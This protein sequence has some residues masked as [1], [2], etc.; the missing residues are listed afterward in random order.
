MDQKNQM[1]QIDAPN[2]IKVTELQ[3]D[4]PHVIERG[5]KLLD[6]DERLLEYVQ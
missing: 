3:K 5:Q 6:E 2:A 1:D 4:V